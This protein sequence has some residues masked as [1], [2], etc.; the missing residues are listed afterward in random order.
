MAFIRVN[1]WITKLSH[2]LHEFINAWPQRGKMFLTRGTKKT[3][4]EPHRGKICITISK[5]K[6]IPMPCTYAQTV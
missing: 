3:L 5:A 4:G 2:E 1:S 6:S